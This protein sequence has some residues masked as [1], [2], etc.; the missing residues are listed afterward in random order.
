MSDLKEQHSDFAF[1][2]LNDV[3]IPVIQVA[4]IGRQTIT[5]KIITGIIKTTVKVI[6]F[7]TH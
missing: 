7:N 5:K 3:N 4:A 6:C 1:H 2:F